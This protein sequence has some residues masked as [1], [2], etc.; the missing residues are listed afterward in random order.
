MSKSVAKKFAS[1]IPMI[2][3]VVT[4]PPYPYTGIPNKYYYSND[5]VKTLQENFLF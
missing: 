3:D 2:S 4:D 1:Y 5:F